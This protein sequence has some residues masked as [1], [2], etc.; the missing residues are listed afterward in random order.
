MIER[1]AGRGYAS[2]EF[3]LGILHRD[4]ALYL[5]LTPETVSRILA[6]LHADNIV[7]WKKKEL[8]IHNKT[9]L[10]GLAGF[11]ICS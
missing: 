8:I 6:K 5:G 3:R 4:V 11:A 10:Q 2:D 7:T 1:Y 9:V